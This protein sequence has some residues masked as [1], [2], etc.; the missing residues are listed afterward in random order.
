MIE[1]AETM[2]WPFLA[3]LLLA[4]IHV[5]LGIHVVERGVIF[6]DLALAQIAAL[7]AVYGLLLGYDTQEDPWTVKAFSLGFA[8]VGAALFAGTRSR[9]ERV[10]H[11]AVIG[12]TYAVALAGTIM[13]G[14]HLAHG[15]EEV[16]ELLAGSVLWVRP[17]TVAFTAVL[18]GLVGLF[19][20]VFRKQLLSITFDPSG[21]RDR[22]LSVRRW[23]FLFYVTFGVVV[24][25]SVAIAGVLLVFSY[26][27]IPAVIA[28]LFADRLAT[29]LAIGW[30]AGTV[31][32][33]VG[34]A[35]SYQADLPSGPTVVV[36]FGVALALVA[37]G[38]WV[39]R[40]PDRTLALTKLSIGAACLAALAFG[41]VALR[42][43]HRHDLAELLV[44]PDRN[45]RLGA[46]D[47]LSH[48]HPP[49]FHAVES[50]L[51]ALLADEDPQVVVTTLEVI[52][53]FDARD[54]LPGA[55]R[56]LTHDDDGV[57]EAA[58]HCVEHFH[59][60]SSVAP[61]LAAAEAEGDAFLRIET[62]IMILERGDQR[63]F[64]IL[65]EV[66]DSAGAKMARSEASEALRA[67][68]DPAP[69][70][71][72]AAL[73]A[74]ANDAQI[75]ALRAWWEDARFDLTFDADARVFRDGGT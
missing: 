18:Y 52:A 48:A 9:H 37:V 25:S 56:L 62:A 72:D 26:L 63:G 44:D 74:D 45:V 55:H 3:C 53:H 66:L 6:V 15:A 46:L 28:I 40:A 38:K 65:F 54:H 16:S 50:C 22:G 17:D 11:E 35:T 20:F 59:D 7:G 19:H 14:A 57:R 73:G 42:K 58:L 29:R 69:P 41:T 67:H 61:L 49:E 64:E 51:P 30:I 43:D 36:T 10:P 4:G 12:I 39:A 47:H 8:I 68:V 71:V 60:P 32:S 5:Y 34:L 24:T 31:L 70:A 21:S 75:A 27:I 13:A 1:L 33:L 23:D 2:I